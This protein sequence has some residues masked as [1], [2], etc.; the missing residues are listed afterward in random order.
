VRT[1]VN[2]AFTSNA[3]PAYV[4]VELGILEDRTLQHYLGI[5]VIGLARQQYLAAHV[6]QVHLFRQRIPI[7]DVDLSAYQ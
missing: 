1:E 2:Y 6:G 3:V 4:E 5:P 7:H